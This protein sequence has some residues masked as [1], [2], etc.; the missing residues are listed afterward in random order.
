M[1]TPSWAEIFTTIFTTT[2]KSSREYDAVVVGAG[3]AGSSAA[4]AL[5]KAGARV[6]LLERRPQIG[7]PV[8]CAE[9]VPRL[10]TLHAPLEPC[11]IAQEVEEMETFLPSGEV[12]RNRF[13][14]Y[15]LNRSLFD[16]SLAIAASQCGAELLVGAEAID[17]T[18]GGLVVECK[19]PTRSR[20]EVHAKVIIGAD[21]PVSTI[22]RLTGRVNAKFVAAAQCE[23]ALKEPLKSTRVYF[24][25][26]YVG[27]YGW[28][29]PKGA[30][31]NWRH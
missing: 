6:L 19:H 23:V 8:Q 7:L 12:V 15:I 28:A 30:T 21:G 17:L 14:G 2:G 18:P 29:F 9:Y 16:K 1:A 11:H 3:P 4:R 22:G 5:A 13:P 31:A 27:G 24:D 10:I 26:A 20:F 25:P